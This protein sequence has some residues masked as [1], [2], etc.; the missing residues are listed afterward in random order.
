MK[1]K[2][3]AFGIAGAALLLGAAYLWMGSSTPPGQE[4]L[5]TLT[6]TNF[7]DFEGAFDKSI[8]GSRLVLLLS[9]T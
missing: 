7:A 9:P 2:F 5:S 1:K 4:P 3:I 8:E 6:S